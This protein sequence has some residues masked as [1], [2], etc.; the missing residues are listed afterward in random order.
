MP[1]SPVIR[2][3]PLA[4]LLGACGG[5]PK[6]GGETKA[7]DPAGLPA[8]DVCQIVSPA[9]AGRFLGEEVGEGKKRI[10]QRNEAGGIVVTNC[11]YSAPSYRGLSVLVRYSA[12]ESPPTSFDDLKAAVAK[13][14]DAVSGMGQDLLD[15]SAPVQ[16]LGSMAYWTPEIK[17]LTAYDGHYQVSVNADPPKGQPDSAQVLATAVM[18]H[19]LGKL[20]R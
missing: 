3:L 15:A 18:Q 16:G 10:D 2:L 4:L 11:L 14:D 6:G 7:A 17:T 9:D 8:I 5:G 1:S 20:P 19:V 12:S 13:G